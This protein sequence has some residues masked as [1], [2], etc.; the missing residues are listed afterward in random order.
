MYYYNTEQIRDYS[1]LKKSLPT[2]ILYAL[3]ISL[4]DILRYELFH[5]RFIIPLQTE[6]T[7]INFFFLIIISI[8]LGMSLVR[9]MDTKEAVYTSFFT[10]MFFY[11]FNSALLLIQ[12]TY[13]DY[14]VVYDFI[15]IIRQG[16]P[17]YNP[18]TDYIPVIG[19]LLFTLFGNIIIYILL[20]F[21]MMFG[22]MTAGYIAGKL[23]TE[24]I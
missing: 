17:Q 11:I 8:I 19:L 6:Q 15:P 2:G 12:F 5:Q 13:L 10:A 4:L 7:P 22:L 24:R 3:L 1:H 23:L 21:P 14:H 20:V 9:I 16:Y 18:I